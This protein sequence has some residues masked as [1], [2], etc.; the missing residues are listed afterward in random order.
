MIP[1]MLD[2]FYPSIHHFV[3]V[4][5]PLRA[6]MKSQV[7]Q[8]RLIGVSAYYVSDD[9]E[10]ERHND[11]VS[12]RNSLYYAAPEALADSLYWTNIFQSPIWKKG[13][14]AIIIDEA[15]CLESYGTFRPAYQALG[16]IFA[17]VDI[18]ILLFTA[19]ADASTRQNVLNVLGLPINTKLIYEAPVRHNLAINVRVVSELAFESEFEW[20]VNGLLSEKSLFKRGLIFCRTLKDLEQIFYWFMWRLGSDRFHNNSQNANMAYLDMFHSLVSDERKEEIG[21]LVMNDS[22]LR[23]LICSSAF[24]MGLDPYNF[25]WVIHWGVPASVSVYIQETYRVGRNGNFATSTVY[26]VSGKSHGK[27]FLDENMKEFIFYGGCRNSFL[28]AKFDQNSVNED[29]G[30]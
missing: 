23:V 15:H 12:G 30:M 16:R 6:L 20:I 13:L 1:L 26:H 5:S 4:V 24:G 10:A 19:T 27:Q 9:N 3:L 18:P 22:H 11:I 29:C 17:V 21:E 28:S 14:K 2:F 7:D 8:L 25:Q